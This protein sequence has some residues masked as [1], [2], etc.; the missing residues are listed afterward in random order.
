MADLGVPV[1][2]TSPRKA[3]ASF[4]CSG[5]SLTMALC[6]GLALSLTPES[7]TA[8]VGDLVVE[9]GVAGFPP[10]AVFLLLMLT[11]TVGRILR[12]MLFTGHFSWMDG[13]LIDGYLNGVVRSQP[14]KSFGSCSRSIT[15]TGNPWKGA[16]GSSGRGRSS[17]GCVAF[18]PA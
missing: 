6:S 7:S 2:V 10:L 11:N 15:E 16:S 17:A 9:P 12:R 1:R 3:A 18:D 4:D 5:L 8:T 14:S 13:W